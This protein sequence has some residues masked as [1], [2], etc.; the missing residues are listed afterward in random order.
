MILERHFTLGGV[1][2]PVCPLIEDGPVLFWGGRT[3]TTSMFGLDIEYGSVF[4]LLGETCMM[5]CK[6]LV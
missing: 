6:F 5:L 2:I 3:T 4:C 1:E